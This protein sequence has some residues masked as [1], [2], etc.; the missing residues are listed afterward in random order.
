MSASPARIASRSESPD[1]ASHAAT[2]YDA[3]PNPFIAESSGDDDDMDFEP[4]MSNTE[5]SEYFET[6][7]EETTTNTAEDEED[8]TTEF[9]DATDGLEGTE[10]HL[11]IE[12]SSD[13]TGIQLTQQPAANADGDEA[14]QAT[15]SPMQILRL[16]NTPNLRRLLRQHVGPGLPSLDDDDDED[17]SRQ[18]RRSRR[19][20]RESIPSPVVPNPEGQRLMQE[21]VFGQNEAWQDELRQRKKNVARRLMMRE[22]GLNGYGA[23]AEDEHVAQVSTR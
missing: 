5:E 15:V 7:D 21:G 8:G 1:P 17:G 23:K 12:P 10:I 20:K 2:I 19:A 4:P 18:R 13:G 22:L 14:P 9:H 16:L 6:G 11:N 3:A